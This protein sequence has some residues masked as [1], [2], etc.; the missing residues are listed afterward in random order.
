M[1]QLPGNLWRKSRRL[2][3][4]NAVRLSC[5]KY[6][7]DIRRTRRLLPF[8]RTLLDEEKLQQRPEVRPLPLLNEAGAYHR[9]EPH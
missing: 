8:M 1:C 7:P 5:R 4:P 6:P 2:A 3:H 9:E